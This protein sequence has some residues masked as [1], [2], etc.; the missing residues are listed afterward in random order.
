MSWEDFVVFAKNFAGYFMILS[1]FIL[2]PLSIIMGIAGVITTAILHT[3]VPRPGKSAYLILTEATCSL[4]IVLNAYIVLYS[5]FVEDERRSSIHLFIWIV[6]AIIA[7][8]LGIIALSIR[9]SEA[10]ETRLSDAVHGLLWTTVILQAI[11]VAALIIFTLH[12]YDVIEL[13]DSE[14]S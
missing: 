11:C 4:I 3:T 8:A 2:I 1:F 12:V 10:E 13:I 7:C 14:D 6:V 5:V 9:P